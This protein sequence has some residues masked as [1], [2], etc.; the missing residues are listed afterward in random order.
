MYN[1]CHVGSFSVN[2]RHGQLCDHRFACQPEEEECSNLYQSNKWSAQLQI[3]YSL[4]CRIMISR[5]QTNTTDILY[6]N[7]FDPP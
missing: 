4:T 2:P 3:D 6:F 1:K 5:K 7:L